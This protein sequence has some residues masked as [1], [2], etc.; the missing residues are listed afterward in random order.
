MNEKHSWMYDLL[1]I[2]VLLMAGYLRLTGFNWGEGYH[3][4]PDELFL[5]GVLDNLRAHVC[6]DPLVPVDACPPDQQ[7]WMTISEYFDSSTSTLSPYN[8]GNAF[9]VYGNLPMTLVRVGME[10][11]AKDDISNSKFFARQMSALAD[12]FTIFLLYLLVSNLYGRKVGL[13]SATFSS[14]AVMQIQQSHFFTSDLFVN[15][16]MF[17]AL[18]F[19]VKIV[20]YQEPEVEKQESNDQETNEIQTPNLNSQI[21]NI[22]R[23]PLFLLSI[24]FGFALGMAM[25]SKINAAA[26][27]IALPAA[28]AV[29]YLI[30]DRKKQ[31]S[32]DYWTLLTILLVAGGLATI[33]SF[34]IFQPYAFSGLGLNSQWVANIAEQRV[35]ANGDADLPWNLQWARRTHLYSFTNLTVWG[36][37]LPLGI[38]AWVGFLL[39]GWR[40]LQ[41]E[42]K[43]LLLWGWTAF[44]FLWQSLQFN[45]T[46]RYQLPVYPL[47]C[48]MAAWAIFE[49]V[50]LREEKE[51][52]KLFEIFVA[53][54]GVVVL[55]TTT[56]WAF[57]FQSIYT[58]DEP[59]MAASRWLFQN[60]EGPVNVKIKMA[61]NTIYSQPLPVPMEMSIQ[62][63]APFAITFTSNRD[64]EVSDIVI[65]HALDLES[66]SAIVLTLASAS[67]PDV[68]LARASE[69][70]DY[71]ATDDP[72]GPTV[73][74]NLDNT[75]PL[76]KGQAYL[77]K[78]ETLGHLLTL[79]GASIAN[80]TGYDWG[81]PIRI[82][83]YDAF[84][85]IYRGDLT[86]EVYW[87]DNADKVTRYVSMLSMADYIVIPTNHQYAQI[88]R[89][90][91]RYP[92]TTYY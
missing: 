75:V 91:E 63:G 4:H 16:F 14:L 56:I 21:T 40:I 26:F 92:M 55:V 71:T 30:Y 44:Y 42:W 1:F 36:L 82:D 79:S 84:G 72:R 13:L 90:P 3:Q 80:E 53:T 58:R 60:A 34:R 43:H 68:A 20:N 25:A 65:G 77:L 83:A 29:R 22:F 18:A 9:F 17:L 81:L 89:L 78:I 15:M 66:P 85:G 24:G 59:R 57:A 86:L 2:L 51:R 7:R 48:M 6:K 69:K 64:G 11:A 19:A 73:E 87:D 62:A 61:D 23:N 28:F 31:L 5:T 74:F 46:M 52:S 12:L 38:L 88:T 32:A 37:G 47:L 50:K 70:V 8:R 33:I 10:M 35:Q 49:M 45:A 27:A 54:I 67:A 41:G 39:M 76:V